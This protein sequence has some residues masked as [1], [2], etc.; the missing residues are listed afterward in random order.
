MLLGP[1]MSFDILLLFDLNNSAKNSSACA[2]YFWPAAAI[3]SRKNLRKNASAS[4]LL[5]FSLLPQVP[6]VETLVRNFRYQ[7]GISSFERASRSP[8]PC[9]APPPAAHIAVTSTPSSLQY[10]A[11]SFCSALSSKP[12]PVVYAPRSL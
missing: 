12:L 1:P 4:L 2:G 8:P 9:L 7:S 6:P 10:F 5:P 11:S 3:L